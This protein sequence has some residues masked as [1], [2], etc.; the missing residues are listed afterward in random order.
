M[1]V[2]A[3]IGA[4]AMV[5]AGSSAAAGPKVGH[6]T[7]SHTGPAGWSVVKQVGLRNYAG[8]NCPGK[9]WNCTKAKRVLQVSAAGGENVA[10]CTNTTPLVTVAS[11]SCTITQVGTTNSA[12][13]YE[14]SKTVPAAA[15]TCMITQT[16]ASNTAIVD[17]L[18]VQTQGSTHN[19]SQTA[20]VN[21]GT[22][23]SP[24]SALNSS[25]VSQDVKQNTAGNGASAE[26]NAEEVN[27]AASGGA[28]VQDAYQSATVKQ[29]ATGTGK[30]D[31][32][33]DQSE[34]QKAH[35]GSSQDQNTNSGGPADCAPD[36]GVF[37][38]NV[39]AN[40][41]QH[42]V[43]GTNADRL[44]QSITQNAKLLVSGDQ[45]QGWFGTNGMDGQVHQDTLI[46]GPG[47]SLNDV[48]Q[49]KSQQETSPGGLQVQF[50]PISCCGFFSQTGGTGANR[51]VINQ[52]ADLR[53]T[54]GTSGGQSLF[55]DATSNSD[56]GSCT[57]TQNGSVNGDSVNNSGTVGPPLCPFVSTSIECT[58]GSISDGPIL[59]LA[60]SIGIQQVV[61]G[62]EIT[63][64][65]VDV[66]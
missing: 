22:T 44:R 11:Q 6:A 20:I 23:L 61:E 62:C 8:P 40:V 4:A 3:L 32:S 25:S 63:D 43:S 14:R 1:A 47:S 59:L 26:D 51:E 12:K 2:L 58:E 17:Q 54:G 28:Q 45:R 24:S 52:K 57:I 39:C 36:V 34:W 49:S 30:N 18:I 66:D 21:Q 16:G 42:G 41:F 50:D 19:G 35:G 56:P 37:S 46:G 33:V 31:S 29:Y 65:I 48:N 38:P 7:K 9:G 15:Q 10:Q 55:I 27:T 53:R 5:L 13:C 64:P 60:D